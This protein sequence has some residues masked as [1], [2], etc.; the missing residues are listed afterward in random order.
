MPTVFA[1][2]ILSS[3]KFSV[4]TINAKIAG[5]ERFIIKLLMEK[6]DY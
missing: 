2:N 6:V 4:L 1:R 5:P 3:A